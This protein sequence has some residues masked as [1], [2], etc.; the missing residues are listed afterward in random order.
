[1]ELAV[2]APARE[3]APTPPAPKE[4]ATRPEPRSERRATEKETPVPIA[5]PAAERG[6]GGAQH[7]YLQNLIKRLAE[8]K[9]YSATIEKSI[10][11]G[12]GSVDVALEREGSRIACE[13]TV[14]TTVEHEIGNVQKCLAAGFEWVVLVA[15]D[16]KTT[17]SAKA[18]VSDA[19][20]EKDAAPPLPESRGTVCVSR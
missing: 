8:E 17:T 12:L 7:K 1:V 19:V 3:S 20:S 13:T 15:A 14:T 5:F 9:G 2:S 6:R 18:L 16:K 10:L 11:D 4:V